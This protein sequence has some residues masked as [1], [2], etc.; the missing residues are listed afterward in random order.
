MLFVFVVCLVLVGT[1][2]FLVG[3]ALRSKSKLDGR[4]II[5]QA[6][7]KTTCL[8][9]FEDEN[10]PTMLWNQKYCTF[11]VVGPNDISS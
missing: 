9:E 1:I 10:E 5:T 4:L 8:F 2:G 3:R 7:G 6:D 11:L